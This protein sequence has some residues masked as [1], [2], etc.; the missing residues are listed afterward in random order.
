MGAL[1]S[2]L[3]FSLLLSGVA[4]AGDG[5]T[6]AATAVYDLG[7]YDALRA[8]SISS[9]ATAESEKAGL[10]GTMDGPKD[11]YR[12]CIWSCRL[13]QD[14]GRK[15]AALIGRNHETISTTNSRAARSMDAHNNWVGRECGD[16]RGG[17]C[18]TFCRLRLHQGKLRVL[19][20]WFEK[21]EKDRGS[22]REITQADLDYFRT[23][24]G[25]QR[26]VE[27]NTTKRH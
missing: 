17:D 13:T 4:Y 5:L 3:L 21:N 20:K 15:E 23:G 1:R 7:Y 2:Y 9:W 19:D 16:I 27:E 6:E 18:T 26:Y 8:K 24:P 25:A 10:R 22:P 11:A 14:I 12:H